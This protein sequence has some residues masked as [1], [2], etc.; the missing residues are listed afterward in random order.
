MRIHF[1][2]HF[3]A[4]MRLQWY[5]LYARFMRSVTK[6]SQCDYLWL[7]RRLYVSRDFKAKYFKSALK[8]VLSCLINMRIE[9]LNSHKIA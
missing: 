9:S 1:W 2:L 6:L 5:A 3:N 8:P 4:Y 7:F